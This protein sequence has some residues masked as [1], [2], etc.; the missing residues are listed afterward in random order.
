MKPLDRLSEYL[1]AIERRLRLIALTRGIAVTAGMALALTIV[2][3]LVINQF[4]FSNGSVIGARVF[5][6][7]GLAFAI[8]AALIIPVIRLNR[9]NAARRAAL[10]RLRRITGMMSAAAMANARPRN[11]KTRAP[12][13][14]PLE[15]ANWL[16]TSTATMVSANATPAVTAMPR[17][18]AVRRSRRSMA[19]RYSLKRSK[20]FIPP[21]LYQ[22]K[23][24]DSPA[25]TRPMPATAPPA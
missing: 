12:I 23:D 10:R 24:V 21:P 17:V 3:V 18:S 1:G 6:F 7:L 19:P 8:A 5:L 14:L 15:K 13:T 22:P 11:R 16:M 4:A 2:A 20:G 25:K 9:R